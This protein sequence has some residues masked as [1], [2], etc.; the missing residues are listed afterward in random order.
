MKGVNGY[1]IARKQGWNP[2]GF[3]RRGR[4]CYI[5]LNHCA[6]NVFRFLWLR[7]DGRAMRLL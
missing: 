5:Q 6:V 4:L 3:H 1:D 2:C 7:P